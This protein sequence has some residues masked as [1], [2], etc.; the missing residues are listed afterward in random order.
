MHLVLL[1]GGIGM[2]V[3]IAGLAARVKAISGLALAVGAACIGLGALGWYLGNGEV[4]RAVATADPE[5]RGELL[6]HGRQLARHPILF[7]CVLCVPAFITGALGL[8]RSSKT[9]S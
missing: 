5:I 8:V 7:A 4:E 2:V 1:T 3:G 9:G 6:A